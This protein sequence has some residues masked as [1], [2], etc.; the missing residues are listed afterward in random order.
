MERVHF[1]DWLRVGAIGAIF[2]Y[3]SLRAFNTEGWHVKNAETSE[4]LT[5]ILGFFATFGLALL[6]LLSGAGARFA[7]RKRTWGTFVRERTA[8]LLVPF[9]IGTLL[10]SPFQRFIEA[11]H[12][13]TFSGG[14]VEFLGHWASDVPDAILHFSPTV[15]GIG[16]HLWFLGFL[17]AFS[18]ISVPWFGALSSRPGQATIGALA[19]R[20]RWPGASLLL[21]LPIA[22][23]LMVSLPG[24]TSEHDWLEFGW[25]F[26]YFVLGYVLVSDE[27]FMAAIRRDFGIAL[28]V[29]LLSASG[30]IVFDFGGWFA[31]FPVRGVDWTYPLMA[32]LFAVE[33]WCW[34]VVVLSVGMHAAWLHHPVSPSLGEAVLPVY[35]LHQPV[36]LAVAFFVVQWPVG[37]LPKAIVVFGASLPITLILVELALRAPIT[38]MLLGA[39]APAPAAGARDGSLLFGQSVSKATA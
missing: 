6:F 27:R 20:L 11:V 1:I 8:R 28:T 17:F 7:L 36:I 14:F 34:T 38:R 16:V 9:V 37:I 5:Y 25:Y 12:K 13:G 33:G 30:L 4:A 22:A 21:A 10:L 15:F 39:R 31:S 29:G 26:G 24:G 32:S 2:V 19:S 23:L 18:V 35:V 3:H